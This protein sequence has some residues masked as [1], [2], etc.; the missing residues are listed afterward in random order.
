M[1]N[2]RNKSESEILRQNAEELLKNKSEAKI[3]ELIE[4]LAFQNEEKTKRADEL[5]IANK[6]LALQQ[7]NMKKI[8]SRVPGLVY[9]YLLRPD[10]TSCFPYA[11]EAIREIYRVSP[12]EVREDASA[13]F[14]NLHPDDLAVVAASIQASAQNLTPWQHEYRVKFDDGTIRSLYGNA[15]P[16]KEV[17]GSVLW[18]GFITDITEE[19][20]LKEE[21]KSSEEQR[22]SIL[23]HVTDVVWSLSWPDLKVN[24]ISQSVEQV[25]GRSVQEF[26]ENP[27]LWADI[28][29]ADD[30]PVSVKA[31]EQLT[32]E[33]SA[34]RECRIV[35]PDG[36]I[37]WVNDKSK[38]IVDQNGMPIRI[39][40]VSRDITER[41]RVEEELRIKEERYRLLA[42]NARDVIWTM[43]LDGTI[44]YISPS[45]E[46][47]RGFTVE[48]A[49]NQPLD[50]ILT[51]DSQV[52]SVGYVQ[53]LYAAFVAGLPLPDFRGELEYYCKDGSTLW[54]ECL[55]YPVLGSDGSSLT[56][57]GVTRDITERKQAEVALRKSEEDFKAIANFA[58]SW[59]AWFNP[60]GKLVWMNSYSVKLTGYTPEEYIAAEDYSSMMIAQEDIALAFDKFQGA[61]QGSSGDNLEI[62]C[63]RKDGSRFWAS[64]SW[65]PIF[66]LNGRSLGFR[67]SIQDISERKK[68][69]EE[70]QKT[71]ASIRTLSMAIEQSPVTTVITDVAGNIQFVN[72][73]FTYITG[74]TAEEAIG[75]NPRIL[76]AGDKP[77]SEYRE[78]WET[79]LSGQNWHGVFKNKKKNGELY[80]ESAVISPVKDNEGTIT[81]FLAVKEDITERKKSE[82]EIK[83]KNEQL[84]KLNAEKDKFFSI[85]SHDL[86]GPFNGLLGLSK[87]MAEELSDLTQEEIQK[88]AGSMRDSATNLF[89]LLENLLEWSRMQ[90]GGIN[91][92]PESTCLMSIINESMR[93]VMDSADKKGIKIR[94]EIPADVE[95]FADQYMLASTIRNLASNAVK[96]TQ[97][98]GKITIAAK[99]V[100]GNSVEF[101]VMDTG[102]GMSPEILDDLFRL[103][104]QSNRRGTENEPSSGLGLLLC[105]DFIEKHGGK[106]WVESEDGKGST[107][108]FT[109]PIAPARN[110]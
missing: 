63:L 82:E 103:D 68:T 96:F 110:Q 77:D 104:V 54:T 74:Y 102:I 67:T 89:G 2:T 60:A 26:T 52:A 47:L 85:I 41:K 20:R 48:E 10:G 95:V 44:T 100:P 62:R 18:H 61:L 92:N 16:Q 39:D 29:H 83:L 32:K 17:D 71:D 5:L 23:N 64:V 19:N 9:Q 46:H 65:R 11:S 40:G 53:R 56:M 55:T 88:M 12:D 78:L 109:L 86:R 45:V 14:A 27:S 13:V 21:L 31:F 69:E 3:L 66:D 1:K 35:R 108:Y 107:F 97:K 81:H 57:L 59:E 15:V 24:F 43:K 22:I 84:I 80:W 6:E 37:V 79:I 7:D 87:M 98:S 75:H 58:A 72:P 33:G 94:Y 101:S 99:T 90:Q 76:K 91:F 70:K 28:V 93:P 30:K 42:E 51:P 8:A 4:E 73:K 50:K 25:L 36:S 38:I 34:V 105:K 106:I 49:M